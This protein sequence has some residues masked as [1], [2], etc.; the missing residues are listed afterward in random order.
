MVHYLRYAKDNPPVL[1]TTLMSRAKFGAP[2]SPDD[3]VS[4]KGDH[5]DDEKS[6]QDLYGGLP[7]PLNRDPNPA[8]ADLLDDYNDEYPEGGRG[9]IVV[10][11][12][13]L[14]AAGTLDKAFRLQASTARLSL[15]CVYRDAIGLWRF[16]RILYFPQRLSWD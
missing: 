2:F 16:P 15:V 10:L 6:P 14:Q 11:G 9:W 3:D 12:C 13:F 4:E 1:L 7:S 5:P 8:I